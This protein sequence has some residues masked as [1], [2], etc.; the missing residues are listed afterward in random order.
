MDLRQTLKYRLRPRNIMRSLA[1]FLP[2]K[3]RF[4]IYRR[5]VTVEPQSPPSFRFKVARTQD[6][7]EGAFKIL[8]DEYVASG[9]MKKTPSGLRVTPYHALPSTSTLIC[10]DGDEVV[11]TVTII[12]DSAFGFPMDGVFDTSHIRKHGSRVAE[13]SSLA[14][15][16]DYRQQRGGVLFPLLKF[17]YHYCVHYF[18]V[19]FLVI[20]VNPKHLDFYRSI[21]FFESLEKLKVESYDF[22][23]GAPAVGAVLNLRQAYED[24]SAYYGRKTPDK[25]LSSYFKLANDPAFEFPQRKYLNISDPII[26]PALLDY[27]FNKRTD[28]LPSMTIRQK[29]ILSALY[30]DPSYDFVLPERTVTNCIPRVAVR[31]EVKCAGRIVLNSERVVNIEVRDVS[32]DGFQ[33]QLSAPVRFGT[34]MIVN[35]ALA[36]FEIADLTAWPVW[37]ADNLVCGFKISIASSSWHKFIRHLE[38][39]STPKTAAV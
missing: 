29:E 24:F 39:D 15:R 14:V 8:H 30:R 17:M 20:A 11:G 38:E 4:E 22:A 37:Q 1:K 32:M 5:F 3:Q 28:T 2:E 36:Q 12:R 10:L 18:G 31:H 25:N 35:I 21:L 27:F 6:E 33:A 9:F 26:T 16:K 7:L 13:I 23:N 34:P 19:D